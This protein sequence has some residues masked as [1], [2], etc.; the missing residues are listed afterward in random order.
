M[1][2][3]LEDTYCAQM[4]S[5]F[6]Q[7]VRRRNQISTDLYSKP[8]MTQALCLRAFYEAKVLQSDLMN[9]VTEFRRTFKKSSH[10]RFS[11]KFLTLQIEIEYLQKQ[12]EYTLNS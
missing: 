3:A 2:T 9:L 7:L 8:E 1:A 6:Q 5:K 4:E 11:Q 10:L 12:L